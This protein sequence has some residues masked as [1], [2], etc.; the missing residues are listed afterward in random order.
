MRDS[1]RNPARVPSSSS[2]FDRETG[3]TKVIEDGPVFV[4]NRYQPFIPLVI[5]ETVRS[6]SLRSVQVNNQD[7]SGDSL[8]INFSGP[9]KDAYPAHGAILVGG[10][11]GTVVSAPAGLGDAVSAGAAV[12]N[13]TLR[14]ND[15]PVAWPGSAIANF[16]EQDQ[17]KIQVTAPDNLFNSGDQCTLNTFSIRDYAGE[18]LDNS[19]ISFTI[20]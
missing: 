9:L 8:L 15:L 7:P 10:A 5:G 12:K 2:Q 6:I 14:C 11:D 16:T 3:K 1:A 20:P 17:V 13:Y 18:L 19:S 4:N